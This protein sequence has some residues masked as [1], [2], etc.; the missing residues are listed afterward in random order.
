MAKTNPFIKLQ[1]CTPGPAPLLLIEEIA[2]NA[3]AS[4]LFSVK[5]YD[6]KLD[7]LLNRFI[8][9]RY[10][11]FILISFVLYDTSKHNE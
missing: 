9:K 5:F 8:E 6:Q 2:H 10:I 1:A 3:E 4:I 7:R 11:F